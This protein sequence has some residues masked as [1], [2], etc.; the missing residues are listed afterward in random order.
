M[1]QRSL[2]WEFSEIPFSLFF[3]DVEAVGPCPALCTALLFMSVGLSNPKRWSGVCWTSAEDILEMPRQIWPQDLYP[4]WSHLDL[5]PLILFNQEKPS[6]Q[7]M[8]VIWPTWRI[9]IRH[10]KSRNVQ[11]KPKL[12]S[13]T[14]PRHWQVDIWQVTT[15]QRRP[16]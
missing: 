3:E 10:D 13:V 5:W 12:K 9:P 11:A 7:P 2:D 6:N 14:G 8:S 4:L 16:G 15:W 1:A